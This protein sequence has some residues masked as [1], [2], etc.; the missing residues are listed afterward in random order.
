M[1]SSASTVLRGEKAR[2]QVDLK[3][4]KW[5]G[6]RRG[7]ERERERPQ[8]QRKPADCSA[9]KAQALFQTMGM[10]SPDPSRGGGGWGKGEGTHRAEG[11][12]HKTQ[13]RPH[14]NKQKPSHAPTHQ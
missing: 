7:R 12:R 1:R 3:I 10:L 13:K 2:G 6:E 5:K 9:A 8:T 4:I 11:T 14:M